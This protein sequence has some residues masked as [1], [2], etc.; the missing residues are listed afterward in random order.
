MLKSNDQKVI[1]KAY[2]Q[3]LEDVFH[4]VLSCPIEQRQDY[5]VKVC[6]NNYV[7]LRDVE[8][9]VVAYEKAKGEEFLD[10]TLSER[11]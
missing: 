4:D 1:E 6:D 10:F 5:L 11:C 9:L 7:L 3:I 8:S 2:W